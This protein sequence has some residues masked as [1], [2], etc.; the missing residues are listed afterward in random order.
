VSETSDN[1]ELSDILSSTD[2][3]GVEPGPF[4]SSGLLSTCGAARL[5]KRNLGPQLIHFD[6]GVVAL[7]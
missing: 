1:S 2:A 5:L 6:R 4:R 7:D 3:V